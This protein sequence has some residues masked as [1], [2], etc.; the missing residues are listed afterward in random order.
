LPV[1]LSLLL[2][3]PS[4]A[5]SRPSALPAQ[6]LAVCYLIDSSERKMPELLPHVG[7]VCRRD[8]SE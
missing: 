3:V 2:C 4:V 8:F 1:E 7:R 6:L 5:W